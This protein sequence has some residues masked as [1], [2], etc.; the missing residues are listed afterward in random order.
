MVAE[1]AVDGAAHGIDEETSAHCLGFDALVEVEL[2]CKG[3][4]AVAVANELDRMKSPRPRAS[5]TW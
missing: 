2:G 3:R 4:L 5:P 1:A